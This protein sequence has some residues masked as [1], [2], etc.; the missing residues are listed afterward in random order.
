MNDD[1]LITAVAERFTSIH[2]D[3]PV[4]QIVSRGRA[5]RTRRRIPAV[6]TALATAAGA[7]VAVT[8]LL[9][10]SHPATAQLA[11]WTVTKQD[12]GKIYV[13]IRELKDPAGL[14]ATLRADGVPASVSFTGQGDPACQPLDG[15]S[16]SQLGAVYQLSGNVLVINPS[17]LP[18]DA[19]VLIHTGFGQGQGKDG[20]AQGTSDRP[21]QDQGGPAHNGRQIQFQAGLVQT[22]QECTGS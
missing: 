13:T 5:V 19:G 20:A 18:S 17:A 9:P 16:K 4:E 11:A 15:V 21:A 3:T 12:N 2:M 1:Q 22:S 8:A 10:A 6:A 7:A 14:Q